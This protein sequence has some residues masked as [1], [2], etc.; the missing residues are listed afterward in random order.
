[1]SYCFIVGGFG[2]DK[3]YLK[4]ND[5]AAYK[6]AFNLSN[7]VWEVVISWNYFAKDTIGK[8]F[9]RS[10][11]S[12]SANIAEGFGRYTKKDKIKFY[13]I[14]IGSLKEAL[15]WNEKAFIRKLLNQES[16]DIILEDLQR[17]NKEIYHLI[18]YTNN[19]LSI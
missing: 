1:L 15:D 7:L 3:K 6:S 18:N 12:I 8:Q 14:S 16:H 10:V 5:I 4:L 11:D 13:R 17:I 19:K 9:C 2:V